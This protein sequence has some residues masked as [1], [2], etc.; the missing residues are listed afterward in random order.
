MVKP[1]RKAIP[2]ATSAANAKPSLGQRWKRAY[3]GLGSNLGDRVANIRRAL[4]RFSAAEVK[5]H[6]LSSM[7]ETAPV[8]YLPQPWFVNCVAEVDTKLSPQ[9]LLKAC[10]SVERA[11]GRRPSIPKGPR[12]IDID[13]LFY[14]N[15]IAHS[16][17]LRIP[18]A[19]LE[20]RRFVLVP[21]CELA[22]EIHHPVSGRT[23]AEMLAE[24]RDTAQ[25]IR[26]KRSAARV[27]KTRRH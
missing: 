25:V 24:T 4:E 5:I 20:E 15:V 16:A 17:F 23:A 12:E 10:K 22:P 13:I 6:R 27:S 19:H 2:D 8:E 7:Y 3:L 9:Q 21:L 1:S 26:M 14:E 18:H 11:L